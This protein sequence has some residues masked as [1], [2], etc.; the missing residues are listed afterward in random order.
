MKHHPSLPGS[1]R[2]IGK[3]E[4]A[5]PSLTQQSGTWSSVSLHP[6]NGISSEQ[7]LPGSDQG[8]ERWELS[9][10][11]CLTAPA[12]RRNWLKPHTSLCSLP[13][14]NCCSQASVTAAFSKQELCLVAAVPS[15]RGNCS[16][17]KS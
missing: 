13:G 7:R 3:E 10:P 14:W 8:T 5:S 6:D 1:K 12:G 4:P 9:R 2:F 16:N 15:G 11:L 17:V